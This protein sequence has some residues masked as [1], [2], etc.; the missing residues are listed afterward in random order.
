MRRGS[1]A[2]SNTS[3]LISKSHGL[4]PA[5]SATAS[6]TTVLREMARARTNSRRIAANPST[7]LS[8]RATLV[9]GPVTRNTAPSRYTYK[10]L[11]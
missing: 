4:N 9:L 3:R 7:A 2:T 6:A 11:L 1:S 10:G 5:S 8:V